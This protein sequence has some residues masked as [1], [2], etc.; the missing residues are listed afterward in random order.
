M[1]QVQR[2][3]L[4]PSTGESA[5]R[6]EGVLVGPGDGPQCMLCTLQFL[7][8][9]RCMIVVALEAGVWMAV[10][11]EGSEFE[12]TVSHWSMFLADY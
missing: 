4:L 6:E 9:Q 2:L 10:S 3:P 5:G 7:C 1:G 11:L 8:C 12:S